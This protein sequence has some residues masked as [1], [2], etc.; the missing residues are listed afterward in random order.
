LGKTR[1]SLDLDNNGVNFV[2]DTDC[3]HC[4]DLCE[5]EIFDLSAV[6]SLLDPCKDLHKI[7]ATLE[8]NEMCE[9]NKV[10][11]MHDT[12]VLCCSV[13]DSRDPNHLE[14]NEIHRLR[15]LYN[16]HDYRKYKSYLRTAHTDLFAGLLHH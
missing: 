7:R 13:C 2:N 4:T 9:M 6:R 5:I 3:V 11:E 10:C 14:R 8:L 1:E 15:D 16:R 12:R